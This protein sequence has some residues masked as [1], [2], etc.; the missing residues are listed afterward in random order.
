MRIPSTGWCSRRRP[1]SRRSRSSR[2]AVD[3]VVDTAALA[4]PAPSL[5]GADVAVNL[6]GRGPESHRALLRGPPAAADRLRAGVTRGRPGR[7]GARGSTRR[8]RW[9]RLLVRVRHPRRSRAARPARAAVGPAGRPARRHAG[10]P[11]RGEP[12]APVAARALGR[13]GGGRAARRA[14]GGRDRL[15]RRARAGGDGRAR[16]GAAGRRRARRPHRPARARGARRPCRGGCSAATPGSPT[17]PPRSGCRRSCSSAPRRRRSG[18]RR[19][20]APQ[21]V[22]LHRGG[23]G[24]PHAD[25]PDPGLLAITVEDVLRR[26]PAPF[27]RLI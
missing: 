24:D 1:R 4:V 8:H 23:R 11:G 9:C 22:A 18:A 15:G 14:E 25:T 6:H 3:A 26:D 21:H 2:G 13:G 5:H 19:P 12:R 27:G 10:P 20:S 16:R 7:P 17:S